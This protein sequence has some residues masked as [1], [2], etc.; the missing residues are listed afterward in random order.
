MKHSD[1]ETL[2][3]LKDKAE[4]D[5]MGATDELMGRVLSGAGREPKG[6]E[7]PNAGVADC[8]TA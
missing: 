1:S 4:T 8:P 2:K 6:N 5:P 3:Q 7:E